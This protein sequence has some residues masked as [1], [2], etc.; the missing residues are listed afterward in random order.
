MSRGE[1][2]NA[3]LDVEAMENVE[4]GEEDAELL[5]VIFIMSLGGG[6]CS[7]AVATSRRVMGGS[8]QYSCVVGA[9]V[10]EWSKAA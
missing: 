5:G 2:E 1:L 7:E 6:G 10:D 9:R 4:R 3:E 8:D